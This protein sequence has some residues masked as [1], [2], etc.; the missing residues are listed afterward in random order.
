MK[1]SWK[2]GVMGVVIG[3]ALGRPVQFESRW[4]VST[5]PITGMRGGGT[6][7]KPIGAWTD[8]SS[9]TLALLC[10]LIQRGKVDYDAIMGNF[11]EWLYEGAFTPYGEAYDVG[12]IT[13]RAIDEYKRHRKPF[14]CGGTA[15]NTNGNGSLMRIL[16][17]ALYCCAKELPDKEAI[18]I[19]HKVGGLTHAHICCNIGCGLYF[20]MTRALLSNAG[21]LKDRLRNGLAEGFA[22]YEAALSDHE[23]LEKYD[24]LRDLDAFAALPERKIYST[25]YVVDTLEAALWSLLNEETFGD[26]LL[27][28]VNLG[29]DTDTVG[30]VAG[31]LAGLYYG[32]EGIPADWV[33]A[34]AS[35]EWIDRVCEKANELFP[36]K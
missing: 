7:N 19:I 14:Q 36:M 24:R 20:F 2:D 25:G 27:R 21:S 3:D 15:E 8:D 13:R 34:I 5:H 26:T 1:N 18:D 12:R 22:Y 31:G 17:A 23:F 28:A 33:E 16:P 30:A 9:L 11:M 35:R 4:D 6:F 29:E 32:S 10:S